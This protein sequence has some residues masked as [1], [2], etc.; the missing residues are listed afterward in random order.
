MFNFSDI[1]N[2]KMEDIKRP[3]LPPIGTYRWQITKIPNQRTSDDDKWLFIEFPI[4]VVEA[5]EDVDTSDY[6]GDVTNHVN[7]LTF[8]F[9]REDKTAF[10][11]TL[12]RLR[13]FLT[14]HVKCADTGAAL[15]EALNASVGQQFLATMTHQQN[16]N[17]PEEFFARVGKTAPLD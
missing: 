11:Q 6:E 4:K 3:P 16:K 9:N 12:F 7:T 1:A 2:T 10:E 17:D 5:L 15:N 14:E 13:K 8:M